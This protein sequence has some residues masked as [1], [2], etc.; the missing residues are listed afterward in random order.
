MQDLIVGYLIKEGKV[1]K[2][3]LEKRQGKSK[4][5]NATGSVLC[6]MQVVNTYIFRSDE[7]KRV[8]HTCK[9]QWI[10]YL[11]ECILCNIQYVGKCEQPKSYHSLRSF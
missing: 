5:C 2:K 1:A 7:T 10:I 4:T 11:L 8:F 9:S 3:I 6:C